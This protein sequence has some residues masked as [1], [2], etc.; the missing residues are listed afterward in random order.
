METGMAPLVRDL[1]GGVIK[2]V[3]PAEAKDVR[4]HFDDIANSNESS[5]TY[6]VVKIE[7]IPM[8][9]L[10]M[11][12]CSD[13]WLLR[14]RQLVSK[15]KEG[16]E[17]KNVVEISLALFRLPQYST[18]IVVTFNNPTNISQSS[19]SC[20]PVSSGSAGSS[21]TWTE[22]TFYFSV[23]SLSLVHPELLFGENT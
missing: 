1:F 4:Y 22:E 16:N 8:E 17:A 12:Q 13:A 2:A 21:S 11:K 3:I 14:G 20:K 15:F 9:K 6:E 19:S 7:P 5:D 10:S 23:T 18:D